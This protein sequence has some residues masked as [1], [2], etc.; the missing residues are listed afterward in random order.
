MV[1]QQQ[2]Q[3]PVGATT[4]PI[5][6]AEWPSWCEEASARHRGRELILHFADDALGDVRLAEGQPFVAIEHDTLGPTV[7]ITIKYGAGVVPVRYVIAQPQEV[8]QHLDA[9]GRVYE[10]TIVDSTG[11]RTFVSLA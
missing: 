1:D 7:A 2:P 6:R 5:P 9:E 4:S 3:D 10:V 8:L 11:R